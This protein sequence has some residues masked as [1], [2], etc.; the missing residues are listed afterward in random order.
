MTK[1]EF[2]K[3]VLEETGMKGVALGISHNELVKASVYLKK[4]L[5]VLNAVMEQA[6]EQEDYDA[7]ADCLAAMEGI[8]MVF[9]KFL[10]PI[11]EQ[12]VKNEKKTEGGKND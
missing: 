5:G 1:E 2:G 11:M 9:K 6:A 3:R 8:D 4:G 7:V 12:S 10:H